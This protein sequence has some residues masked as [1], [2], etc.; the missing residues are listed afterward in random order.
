MIGRCLFQISVFRARVLC[1]VI[2]MV[3]EDIIKEAYAYDDDDDDGS[4]YSVEF[5]KIARGACN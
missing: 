3:E 2:R 1:L 5:L 4:K